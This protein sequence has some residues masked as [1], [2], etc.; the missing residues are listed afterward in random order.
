VLQQACANRGRSVR[1]D[2]SELRLKADIALYTKRFDTAHSLT[3]V[4]PRVP[5]PKATMIAL[6]RATRKHGYDDGHTNLADNLFPHVLQARTINQRL[7]LATLDEPANTTIALSDVRGCLQFIEPAAVQMLQREWP[8]WRPPVL[9]QKLLTVLETSN[10][11]VYAGTAVQ[12]RAV[13]QANI[14][15]LLIS[16]RRPAAAALTPAE[17][18]VAE[19]AAQGMQN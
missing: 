13:R 14:F 10:A 12:V 17:L 5:S 11:A 9:P 8:D 19:M 15:C 2:V 4:S 1:A 7:A 16:L 18:R 6:W 3:F